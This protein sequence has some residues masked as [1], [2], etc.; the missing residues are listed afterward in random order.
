M[1]VTLSLLSYRVWWVSGSLAG[2]VEIEVKI[3]HQSEGIPPQ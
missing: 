2:M 3:N 1:C